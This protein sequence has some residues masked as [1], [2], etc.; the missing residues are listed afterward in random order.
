MARARVPPR[1]AEALLDD[2]EYL[3]LLVR[4]KP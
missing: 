1:I 3:D 2:P 4:S